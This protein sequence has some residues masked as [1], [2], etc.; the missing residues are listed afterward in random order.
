MYYSRPETVTD[1]KFIFGA[2]QSGYLFEAVKGKT[3][4]LNGLTV[5]GRTFNVTD[6]INSTIENCHCFASLNGAG[7]QLDRAINLLLNGCEV[8]RVENGT[9]VQTGDGIN[10]HISKDAIDG[11]K[12]CS[13]ELRNCWS[14]DNWNDGY[15]DHE[16]CEG[17]INGGLYEHNCLGG[18]GA[19]LTPAYGAHDIIKDV[20]SQSNNVHGLAYVGDGTQSSYDTGVYGSVQVVS[21]V[22][23]FNRGD[24]FVFVMENQV[25][26][27]VNCVAYGNIGTGFKASA[28]TMRCINTKSINNATQYDGVES[29]GAE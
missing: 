1:D 28:G 16:G 6:T 25:G 13:F 2:A 17:F 27:F 3:L 15:S 10:V 18:A 11:T 12:V 22:S 5:Y 7:F 9:S 23:R 21:S 14:H 20:I 29:I 4:T 24:G 8:S 26:D 19:G